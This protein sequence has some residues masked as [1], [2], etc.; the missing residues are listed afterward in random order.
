M[1]DSAFY[2]AICNRVDLAILRI[3]FL[4]FRNGLPVRKLSAPTSSKGLP[5]A[6]DGNDLSVLGVFWQTFLLKQTVDSHFEFLG[7]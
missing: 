2:H 4:L 1:F 7:D 3:P 6:F 5:K